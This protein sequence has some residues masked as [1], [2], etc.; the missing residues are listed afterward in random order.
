MTSEG[1][2]QPGWVLITAG[3]YWFGLNASQVL[4]KMVCMVGPRTNQEKPLLTL[5][6]AHGLV[7]YPRF[8]NNFKNT[9]Q[10]SSNTQGVL[11]FLAQS[12]EYS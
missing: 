6:S 2:D 11:Q 7:C 12:V 4:A 5:L 10:K 8:K 1:H 9:F 3:L